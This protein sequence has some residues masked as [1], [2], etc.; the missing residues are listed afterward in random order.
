MEGRGGGRGG[1]Q[2]IRRHQTLRR[3]RREREGH[4]KRDN[5]CEKSESF[6]RGSG[7]KKS[8]LKNGIKLNIIS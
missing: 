2:E 3:E 1:E 6:Q 8:Y 7:K 5:P 4:G